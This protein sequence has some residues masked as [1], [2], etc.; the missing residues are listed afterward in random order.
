MIELNLE[1]YYRKTA[2]IN[3][4]EQYSKRAVKEAGEGEAVVLTG[5][6]PVWMYLGV[7]HALHG[8]VCRLYYKSPLTGEVLIFSHEGSFI[9]KEKRSASK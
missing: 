3:R 6:A 1:T 4:L 2:L 5:K 7:A 9:P 8:V